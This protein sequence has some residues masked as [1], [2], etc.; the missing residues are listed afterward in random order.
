MRVN[1]SLSAVMLVCAGLFIEPVFAQTPLQVL[2]RAAISESS[3]ES[4]KAITALR[5][6]GAKGIEAFLEV[7]GSELQR[8]QLQG[9]RPQMQRLSSALDAI[10]Q[11]RDCYASRLYWHTDLEQAKAVAKATG[12]PILSLRLLGRLDE[13]L[14]CANS[15]FFRI[16]LYP[17]AE[18]SNILRDRFVLHWE[19]VRPAPRVTIDFGD[20]RRLERTL[21]GNSIHYILDTDGRPVDALP[22]LYGPQAFVK[23]LSKIEELVKQSSQLAGSQRQA[24]L[25]QYHSARLADIEVAWT[26]DLSK[27]GISLPLP[28]SV[29]N[30]QPGSNPPTALEAGELAMTKSR[31]ELPI[32][33]AI[34]PTLQTLPT[35]MDDAKWAQLAE[36]HAAD[37][38]LDANSQALMRSKNPQAYAGKGENA[39]V[40]VLPNFEQAIALDTVRNEY[41]FHTQIHEW[42]VRGE[43]T[44]DVAT[45]NE[46][47]YA[48]LFLTPSSDP[49]LGLFPAGTYTGIENDGIK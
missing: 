5:A 45:L 14:S 7:Y 40:P 31:V 1:G 44:D 33:R 20:G 24:F 49:W 36:L 34:S 23:H 17:N 39:L 4:A 8:S 19:S 6:Q 48:E 47:V 41:L 25:S 46:R 38:R 43:S 11:Q 3:S 27:L 21:T 2:A 15:R 13:E 42:F 28:G 18:V 35:V 29:N 12:K 22:G 37:A 10:C 9:N 30:L 16:A 32:V 26:A